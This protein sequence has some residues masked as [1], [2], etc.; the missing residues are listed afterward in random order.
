MSE[1]KEVKIIQD[2]NGL[3]YAKFAN[4]G[5]LP[6]VLSGMWTHKNDLQSR[7]SHYLATRKVATEAQRKEAAKKAP[8][9]RT[10]RTKKVTE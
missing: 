1:V 10:T 2:R 4:G 3:F 8:T 6:R 5:Q 7:I 9:K